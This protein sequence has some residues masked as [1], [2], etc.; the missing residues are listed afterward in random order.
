LKRIAI[1][2]DDKNIQN[3]VAAFLKKEGYDVTILDSAEAGMELWS[4]NPPDMW[5]LDIMLPGMDGYEFC[6]EI[7]SKSE[8]PIII[9]SAKD[10]EIDKILGLELGGDDYLTKPFS[11]REL[12]ARVKRLFKRTQNVN[13]NSDHGNDQHRLKLDQLLIDMNERRVFW[14]GEE[15]DVTTKEFDMLVLFAENINRAFSREELLIQVWGDDYFGS[16][17]AVDDLVKRLR[18][19]FVSLPLETVWGFGYRLR[20]DEE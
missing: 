7:R 13:N 19:K 9:I 11:P 2:E 17:R 3:I 14:E 5:I 10:E 8:V 15:K 18:K 6:K 12:T 1:V 16:D 20:Y 4:K